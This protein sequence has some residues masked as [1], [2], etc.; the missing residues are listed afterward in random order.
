MEEL[1]EPREEILISPQEQYESIA[2]I[3]G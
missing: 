3:K 2:R 1:S